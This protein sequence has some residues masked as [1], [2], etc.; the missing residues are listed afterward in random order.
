MKRQALAVTASAVSVAAVALAVHAGTQ[1]STSTF[2]ANITASSNPTV[3][4]KPEP[5]TSG[6]RLPQPP[7]PSA[8]P[9]TPCPAAVGHGEITAF[10]RGPFGQSQYFTT[11]AS[12]EGSDGYPYAVYAGANGDDPN[13]GEI[14]IWRMSRDQCN[15]N[16]YDGVQTV[17]QDAAP[18][19]ADTLTAVLDDQVT[20][21]S[22]GGNE[23]TVDVVKQG[24]D[25]R[26]SG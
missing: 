4:P 8:T 23:H 14:I 25:A 26:G 18:S 21:R 1:G 7:P 10:I 19:G 3:T 24:P 9:N 5:T 11:T 13:Q 17:V 15:G 20:F 22:K 16:D 12:F 6:V 2:G